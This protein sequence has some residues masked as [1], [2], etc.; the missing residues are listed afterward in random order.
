MNESLTLKYVINTLN[1]IKLSGKDNMEKLL[2]V[3]NALEEV[4]VS[5]DNRK[6]KE[7]NG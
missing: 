7:T 5:L 1:D 3:I 2:G 4:I 6:D